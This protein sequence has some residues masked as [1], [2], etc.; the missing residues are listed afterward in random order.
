MNR[1][2]IRE[3]RRWHRFAQE[4][5][6]EA[7]RQ[8]QAGETVPRHPA[9]LAQQAAEKALK[10]VLVFEQI[11]FPFTHNLDV[12][13]QR[14]PETWDAKAVRADLDR[15]SEYAVDARYPGNWPDL[16]RDDAQ[17]AVRDALRLVDAVTE[18][19]NARLNE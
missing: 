5:I 19:L 4:D 11:E 6:E 18:D 8:M 9:W 16:T 14:I 17:Q 2:L 10:T 7:E 13:H 3:V 15:L 1:E 12:L